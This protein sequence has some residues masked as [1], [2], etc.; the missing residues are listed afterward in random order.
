MP[1]R[2]LAEVVDA[3]VPDRDGSSARLAGAAKNCRERVSALEGI[4]AALLATSRTLCTRL[5]ASLL[6][7]DGDGAR[8]DTNK[9]SV[10]RESRGS[11]DHASRSFLETAVQLETLRFKVAT[12]ADTSL[13]KQALQGYASLY[14]C[15]LSIGGPNADTA[16]SCDRLFR[17]ASRMLTQSFDDL[18]LRLSRRLSQ[19]SQQIGWPSVTKMQQFAGDLA[20]GQTVDGA[21]AA[22]RDSFTD[23]L[24]FQRPY[25]PKP[26]AMVRTISS[27]PVDSDHEPIMALG[28]LAEPLAVRLRYHFCGSRPTNRLDKPEWMYHHVAELVREHKAFLTQ[29]V[30]PMLNATGLARVDAKNEFVFFLL[31][32]VA[33]RIRTDMALLLKQSQLV[34]HYVHET[35]LFDDLMRTDFAYRPIGTSQAR[36]EGLGAQLTGD[37][38]WFE[39]WVRIEKTGA[40]EAL[41]QT[42][43]GSQEGSAWERASSVDQAASD[44]LRPSRSSDELVLL[45]EGLASRFILLPDFRHRLYFVNEVVLVLLADYLEDVL[46]EAR[47]LVNL[48]GPVFSISATESV[49]LDGAG[50]TAVCRWIGSLEHLSSAMHDWGESLVALLGALEPPGER[51]TACGTFQCHGLCLF[52]RWRAVRRCHGPSLFHSRP[53]HHK[54]RRSCSPTVPAKTQLV[55]SKRGGRQRRHGRRSARG[56]PGCAAGGARPTGCERVPGALAATVPAG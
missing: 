41:S 44:E 39:A 42:L 4:L 3:R 49:R 19:A 29:V 55:K 33:E 7:A 24:A 40:M 18:R 48:S 11:E 30:Q 36:W 21:N 38:D 26:R 15:W 20:R 34:P 46:R 37:R 51:S 8:L 5:E 9:R 12:S 23:L 45:I 28:V 25:V 54:H 1:S 31:V 47:E 52:G 10:A 56:G 22:F 53:G 32:P 16:G 14:D 43:R 50:V 13:L 27:L 2:L 35:L 17:A 6:R